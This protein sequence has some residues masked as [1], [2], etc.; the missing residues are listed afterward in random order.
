[1][2]RRQLLKAAPAALLLAGTAGVASP[3]IA[4]APSSVGAEGQDVYNALSRWALG[5][6][7][8]DEALMRSAFTEDARFIFRAAGGGP[9]GIFN[10]IDAIMDLFLDTLAGQTDVRRHVTANPYMEKIDGRTVKVTTYLVLISMLQ[11]GADLLVLTTGIYRDTV[12]RRGG[13]WRIRERDLTLDG[14]SERPS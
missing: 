9:P 8:R 13:V 14:S 6:D 3:A 10:G 7:T 2:E 1:M 4:A 5:Y 12:V 11:S